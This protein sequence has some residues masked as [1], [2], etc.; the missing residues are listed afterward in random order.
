MGAAQELYGRRK[1]GSEFPVEISLSP[2]ES[3]QVSISLGRADGSKCERCWHWETTVG[4]HPEHPG[5]CARCV[6]AVEP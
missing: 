6:E 4:S 2:I 1:D 5:L 3:E